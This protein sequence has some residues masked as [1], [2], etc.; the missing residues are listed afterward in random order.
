MTR[1]HVVA[2]IQGRMGSTRLPGKILL[3]LGG[4]TVL[5]NVVA[6]VQRAPL[7]HDLVIATTTAAADDVVAS[8][9]YRLGVDVFRGSEDD[10]LDRY[11]GA[12]RHARAD[13]IVRITS[14]CPLLDASVADLVVDRYLSNSGGLDYAS[15]TIVRSYP[16]GLD[17]EVFSAA[18]L[19]E[20]ARSARAKSEREHV[21]Q[22]FYNNPTRFRL[23]SVEHSRDLSRHRWTL[24]TPEDLEF[25][26]QVFDRLSITDAS[27][28]SFLRVVEFLDRH[29][30]ISALN[31][32]V[33]QKPLDAYH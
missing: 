3:V 31:A 23:G 6:R 17:V 16:R 27:I 11:Q 4:R 2:I 7:I 24:D 15:N 20:A 26:R 22:Y 14:D 13:A 9:A 8:E 19:Q 30:E 18:K 33:E 12:A 32:F 28:P 10:V 29:P 1:P 5:A 21:T 25:M